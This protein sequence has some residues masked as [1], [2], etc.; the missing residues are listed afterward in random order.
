MWQLNTQ[1]QLKIWFSDKPEEFLGIENELRLIHACQK[2][3]NADFTL[4][5]SSHCLSWPAHRH[6]KQFCKKH[7]VI[8]LDFDTTVRSKLH[9]SLDIALY[10]KAKCEIRYSKA[11]KGG[12]LAAASDCARLLVP[13]LEAAGIYSDFDVK[14]DFSKKPKQVLVK[15]PLLLQVDALEKEGKVGY[16]FNNEVLAATVNPSNQQLSADALSQLRLLQQ[17]VLRRYAHPSRALLVSSIAGFDAPFAY[18]P[19]VANVV[20]YYFKTYTEDIFL[21]RQFIKSLTVEVFFHCQP[22]EVRQFIWQCSDIQQMTADELKSRLANYM[23][24]R[25]QDNAYCMLSTDTDDECVERFLKLMR[26]DL[27]MNSV[28][29]V[30]GPSIFSRLINETI[31]E[32]GYTDLTKYYLRQAWEKTATLIRAH[33]FNGNNLSDCLQS[34]N[35]EENKEALNEQDADVLEAIGTLGDQSWLLEGAQKKLEREQAMK[36]AALR[37]EKNWLMQPKMLLRYYRQRFPTPLTKEPQKL[38]LTRRS[39]SL[40]PQ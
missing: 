21:Y 13:V 18:F 14:L 15:S 23:R 33:G 11:K 1:K 39:V 22:I 10:E 30:S 34:T 4:L 31:P 5:Y 36:Q 35:N 37:I 20:I 38:R 8:P 25:N 16:S 17:E 40:L 3:P 26:F 2:N 9:H 19:E 29:N 32:G 7:H 28:I 6:L 27:Q 12:N 24:A